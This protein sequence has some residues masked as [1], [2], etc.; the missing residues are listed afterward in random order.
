MLQTEIRKKVLSTL[1][2]AE[3]IVSKGGSP[4]ERHANANEAGQWVAIANAYARLLHD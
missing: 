3:R 1:G 4:A 2:Q